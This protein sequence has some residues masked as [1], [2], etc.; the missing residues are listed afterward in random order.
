VPLHA[1]GEALLLWGEAARHVDAA[2]ARR[3]LQAAAAVLET[4]DAPG[5]AYVERVHADLAEKQASA[6]H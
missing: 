4:A 5:S 1:R 3:L 2:Q 6:A